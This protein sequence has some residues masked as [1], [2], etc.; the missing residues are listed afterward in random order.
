M[1]RR[2]KL[3]IYGESPRSLFLAYI[4]AEFKF[5]VYLLDSSNKFNSSK[6][7]QIFS[8][9]NFSKDLLSKFG[10]WN[11]FEEISYCFNS[12]CLNDNLVSDQIIF[13]SENFSKEDLN[14]IAWT[15]N[16]SEIKK[17]LIDKLINLDN[18][19]FITR[20]QL[21]DESMNFDFEFNFTSYGDNLKLFKF[22]LFTIKNDEKILIF[23][24]YLRGN[25]QKRL[26]EINT[27]EGLL[28][29][30]PLKKNL[31]QVIWNKAPNQ[32]QKRSFKSKSFFLDNLTTILPS[33]L[34][35][36]QIIGEI[37]S[38][39]VHNINPIYLIKSKSI[40]FNENKFT[41][42]TLYD[43]DYDIFI[44]NIVQI[45]SLLGKNNN[46]KHISFFNKLRFYY[47]LVKNK[48]FIINFSF[49]NLLIKFLSLN[50]MYLLLLRKILFILFK[51]INLLSMFFIRKSNI[52]NTKSI[53]N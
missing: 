42:N 45:F 49:S 3:K 34:K 8:F 5:D 9:S 38:I 28:V 23:N 17:L 15:A 26:Y 24:V 51:R 12:F 35:I 47:L 14:P 10:S 44:R 13:R 6:D 29:F 2:L 20:N 25:I 31:Y 41:S 21:I 16:S 22:P 30:T 32:I 50:N 11:E 36:D 19:H 37:N 39:Y 43:L 7:D 46:F 4:F 27:N 52:D 48:E 53:H 40:Y 1:K 18:V 33:E